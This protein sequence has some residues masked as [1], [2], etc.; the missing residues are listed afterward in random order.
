LDE[1]PFAY[2]LEVSEQLVR[3]LRLK[4]EA[5]SKRM[6]FYRLRMKQNSMTIEQGDK[7]ESEN[8]AIFEA[9]HIEHI[10]TMIQSI[11]G[12]HGALASAHLLTNSIESDLNK[13][14]FSL[15]EPKDVKKIR[16]ALAKEILSIPRIDEYNEPL[17][18]RVREL[19][20]PTLNLVKVMAIW[21]LKYW[22]EFK[23]A[24]HVYAHNYRFV[25]FENLFNFRKSPYLESIV[26]FLDRTNDF[27]V[28]AVYIGPL[29][30]AVMYEL[31]M[32]LAQ[33]E[34]WIY[35]NMQA[36]VRN[37]YN[38]VLPL[39][40]VNSSEANRTEYHAIRQSQGYNLEKEPT[41]LR[42]PLEKYKK[43]IELHEEF[44]QVIFELTGRR[45]IRKESVS[46]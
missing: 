23:K 18:T 43:Q 31:S 33:I 41:P 21:S 22:N 20:F 10:F 15:I 3:I 26:G 29:Q 13:I 40:L 28:E 1:I 14:L 11:E 25:F 42:F 24:R 9:M 46:P 4:K 17:R 2:E 37:Q 36:F 45:L 8:R 38:P 30:M 7:F 6:D 27:L 12:F 32:Q 5:A 16:E 39:D 34:Q 35:Q 44:L 19:L